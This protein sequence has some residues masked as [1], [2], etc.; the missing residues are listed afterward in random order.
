[1]WPSSANIAHVKGHGEEQG[2]W[3]I[4]HSTFDLESIV[5]H[6]FPDAGGRRAGEM[7]TST[8]GILQDAKRPGCLWRTGRVVSGKCSIEGKLECGI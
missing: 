1:M 2:V 6:S 3:L 5:A 8:N 7:A 4:R